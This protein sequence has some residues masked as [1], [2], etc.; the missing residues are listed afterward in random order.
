MNENK[1][2]DEW[3][4]KLRKFE[5]G[6]LSPSESEEFEVELNKLEVLQQH[7]DDQQEE[8]KRKRK[9][10]KPTKQLNLRKTK[11]KLRM[12]QIGT[13]IAA[14]LLF[15]IISSLLTNLF[16]MT[17]D[18]QVLY[19]DV[20]KRV[21]DITKPGISISGSSGS[22]SPYFTKNDTYTIDK[23]V[24]SGYRVMG[25]LST[26]HFFSRLFVEDKYVVDSAEMPR[27]YYLNHEIPEKKLNNEWSALDKIADVSV[28]NVY[29]TFDQMYSTEDVHNLFNDYDVE[30]LFYPVDTGG[31]D[32]LNYDPIGFSNEP[33]W[34][35]SDWILESE[36][37]E[38]NESTASYAAPNFEY[39]DTE[40]LQTQFMKVLYFLNDYSKQTR[41]I[42]YNLRSKVLSSA[43]SYLEEKGV[44]HYGAVI[45]GPTSEIMKMQGQEFI[46]AIDIDESEFYNWNK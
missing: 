14:F 41:E 39:G 7:M 37:K 40:V 11:W 36:T 13:I 42:N 24:G 15:T 43:I 16:F 45:T 31:E 6:E 33:M 38:G 3:K 10:K 20:V 12:E 4:E 17:G 22:I 28:S 1:N 2:D 8:V 35:E 44:K 23:Q 5:A 18:R 25:E 30:I 9:N 34:L 26:K 21:Y 27:F 29:I 32:A 19:D 46:H